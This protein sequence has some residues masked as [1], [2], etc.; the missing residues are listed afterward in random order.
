[1]IINR[2]DG[3]FAKKKDLLGGHFLTKGRHVIPFL[4]LDPPFSKPN[5]NPEEL[6]RANLLAG[7][8]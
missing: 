1:M 4:S 8:P 5:G 7:T 6:S 3:F 2:F